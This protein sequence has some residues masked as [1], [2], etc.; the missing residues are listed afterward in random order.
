MK[1]KA[2]RA[3]TK[4][5]LG[6]VENQIRDNDPPETRITMERLQKS[7]IERKE[8]IRLIACVVSDEIFQVL[9]SG[10]PSDKSRY[11]KNLSKLPIMPWE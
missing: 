7:G 9:K 2:P 11:A 6:V 3:V 10:Q 1:E 5:I 4:A 8:A